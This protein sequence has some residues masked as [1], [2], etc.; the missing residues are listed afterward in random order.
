MAIQTLVL[1]TIPWQ[2]FE[3]SAGKGKRKKSLVVTVRDE[4]GFARGYGEPAQ[5]STGPIDN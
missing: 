3:T 2:E 4:G 5:G 1:T